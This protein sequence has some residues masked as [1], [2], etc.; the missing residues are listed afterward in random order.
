MSGNPRASSQLPRDTRLALSLV[1]CE[2]S[3]GVREVEQPGLLT[4][5]FG[6]PPTHLAES[7]TS[8]VRSEDAPERNAEVKR[9][10]RPREP[11]VGQRH[12]SNS[13]PA[14]RETQCFPLPV[15][16]EGLGARGTAARSR[17]DSG[18]SIFRRR[19]RRD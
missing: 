12:W 3:A 6:G 4:L 19:F 18:L 17:R 5:Q 9:S 14:R 1:H 11:Y 8:K 7:E 13:A 15:Q 10:A 2:F 16:R